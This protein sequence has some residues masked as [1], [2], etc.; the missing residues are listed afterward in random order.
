MNVMGASGGISGR[1]VMMPSIGISVSG[2]KYPDKMNVM[3]P[4]AEFPAGTR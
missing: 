1:N 3:G 2:H 4:G